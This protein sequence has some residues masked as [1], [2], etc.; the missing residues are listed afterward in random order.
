MKSI[1]PVVLSVIVASAC[2]AEDDLRVL[3]TENGYPLSGRL[4]EEDLKRQFS[5]QL[6]VRRAPEGRGRAVPRFR[7]TRNAPGLSR[8]YD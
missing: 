8:R 2:R 3:T 5:Q 4:L 1:I 6:D 7:R